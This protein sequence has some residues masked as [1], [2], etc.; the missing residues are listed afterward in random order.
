MFAGMHTTDSGLP[1]R[2]WSPADATYPQPYPV[3]TPSMFAT[4]R[5]PAALLT[6]GRVWSPTS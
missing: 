6:S 5:P 1:L 4:T 2:A 3:H